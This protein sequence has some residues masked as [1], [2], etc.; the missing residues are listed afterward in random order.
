MSSKSSAAKGFFTLALLAL[1]FGGILLVADQ[2]SAPLPTEPTEPKS[3]EAEP[4]VKT[5]TEDTSTNTAESIAVATVTLRKTG[6]VTTIVRTEPDGTERILFTD[7][8]EELKLERVLGTATDGTRVFAIARRN[9]SAESSLVEIQLDGT[10][11]LAVRRSTFPMS[12]ATPVVSATGK[13]AAVYFNNAERDFGFNLVIDSL[14]GGSSKTVASDTAG[15]GPLAWSPDGQTIAF[16]R[17][18]TSPDGGTVL[19][20][21]DASGKPTDRATL[22]NTQAV[23]D[24]AWI[25]ENALALV[26]EPRTADGAAVAVVERLSLTDGAR[27]PL[28]DIPGR[29]RSLCVGAGVLGVLVAP[30]TSDEL[31]SGTIHLVDLVTGA[32][33]ERRAANQLITIQ[34]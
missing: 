2:A 11:D 8:D 14:E 22:P 20:T 32:R 31:P 33:I 4:A 5:T 23:V 24:V 17:G 9:G 19:A 3:D 26:V 15:I 30:T 34:K 6:M 27:A 1:G 28:I 7:T 18:Q 13:V 16:A 29:E 25:D 21:V 12:S 10:G